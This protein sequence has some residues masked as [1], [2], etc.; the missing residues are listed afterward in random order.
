LLGGL[1]EDA[2]S[3]EKPERASQRLPMKL[4]ELAKQTAKA[5]EDISRKIET[6]QTD[7]KESGEAIATISGLINPINHTSATIA[8]A[9][10]EQ[11]ATTNEM[12]R[13][14]SDAARG[15]G[16]ITKTDAAQSTSHGAGDSQKAAFELSK[17][18]NARKELTGK[19]KS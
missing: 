14:V 8:P 17:M 18:A 9:V 19:F 4:K 2:P 13:R 3:R 16:E 11:N 6:I 10:E 5:T 7:T 1:N 12:T 15:S